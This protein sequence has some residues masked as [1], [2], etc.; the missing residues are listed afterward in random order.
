MSGEKPKKERTQKEIRDYV[1][2]EYKK[3]NPVQRKLFRRGWKKELENTPGFEDITAQPGYKAGVRARD[4]ADGKNK[5]DK[6][7]PRDCHE[8]YGKPVK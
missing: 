2:K 6:K 1:R 5:T 8:L 7:L 3:L 4:F